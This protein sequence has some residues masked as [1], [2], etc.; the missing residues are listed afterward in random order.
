MS[1]NDILT[2]VYKATGHEIT[3]KELARLTLD[4]LKELDEMNR[5]HKPHY[6]YWKIGK[7]LKELN[8]KRLYKQDFGSFGD[9]TRA[10]LNDMD[11]GSA[12]RFIEVA[13]KLYTEDGK[14]FLEDKGYAFSIGQLAEF[15]SLEGED[16]TPEIVAEFVLENGITPKTP[17]KEIKKIVKAHKS[18]ETPA[19][20]SRLHKSENSKKEFDPAFRTQL[21]ELYSTLAAKAQTLMVEFSINFNTGPLM[22]M[23]YAI[24]H[25]SRNKCKHREAMPDNAADY[26]KDN[27]PFPVIRLTDLCE[28]DIYID[29]ISVFM[30]LKSSDIRNFDFSR[31]SGYD[32]E[33]YGYDAVHRIDFSDNGA[34]PD[35]IRDNILKSNSQALD[36]YF[37]FPFNTDESEILKLVIFLHGAGFFKIKKT[38]TDY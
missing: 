28:V 23:S 24:K 34:A 17:I 14:Q 36:F 7:Y 5:G 4:I 35:K 33:V 26:S 1:I 15:K 32:F 22:S 20:T 30:R 31:L 38:T 3:N 29:V 2:E 13:T 16:T 9:Y 18:F 25:Q 12:Y 11:K 8:F 37:D 21:N 6:R 27:Y 10:M 19:P